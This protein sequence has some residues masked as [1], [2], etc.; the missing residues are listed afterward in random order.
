MTSSLSNGQ[1][2]FNINA[3]LRTFEATEPTVHTER[4]DGIFEGVYN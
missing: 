1:G 4:Y 2:Y 3:S